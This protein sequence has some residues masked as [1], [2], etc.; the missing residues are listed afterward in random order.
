MPTPPIDLNGPAPADVPSD[1]DPILHDTPLSVP[2]SKKGPKRKRQSDGVD[3][4]PLRKKAK[5]VAAAKG[6]KKDGPKA[7][8]KARAVSKATKPKESKLSDEKVH[9][10]DDDSIMDD[11]PDD[12]QESTG[13]FLAGSV[14][15]SSS[16]LPLTKP[17]RR[18][19]TEDSTVREKWARIRAQQENEDAEDHLP[20][21]PSRFSQYPS[22]GGESGAPHFLATNRPELGL[23]PRR[24][25]GHPNDQTDDDSATMVPTIETSDPESSVST[26]DG[27]D[28][29]PSASDPA[30]FSNMGGAS[31]E[32]EAKGY[33]DGLGEPEYDSDGNLIQPA[34]PTTPDQATY[35]SDE[36]GYGKPG[37]KG[38]LMSQK[39]KLREGKGKAGRVVFESPR[40]DSEDELDD[41]EETS[42]SNAGGTQ[43]EHGNQ[44]ATKK[45][46]G[47]SKKLK[48]LLNR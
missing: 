3:S 22:S 24:L 10:S 48:G 33:D 21:R 46:S 2:A 40:R 6:L 36:S 17:R 37:S 18:L 11:D 47:W 14:P 31:D 38:H 20:V 44:S 43:D 26:D 1:D 41:S 30:L 34:R 25:D 23:I 7:A 28:D 13:E 12:E 9:P 5:R 45:G 27:L 35:V 39:T 42:P 19:R 8:P 32:Y 15:Q 16:P 4:S 29:H